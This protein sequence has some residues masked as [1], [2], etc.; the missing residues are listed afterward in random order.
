MDLWGVRITWTYSGAPGTGSTAAKRDAVRFLVKDTDEN[1]QLV[2]DEELSFAITS[3]GNLFRAAAL[4]CQELAAGNLG[5]KKVG[6]LEIEGAGRDY[7]SLA[8]EY[9]RRAS[10]QALP[11]VG[12]ISESAKDT[13]NQD[14]DRVKNAFT[15][16]LLS[17]VSLTGTTST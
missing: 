1:N 9:K 6:D 8:K 12:G 7:R 5:R 13:V 3:E 15:R 2:T 14:T 17:N 10:E 16:D 11:F 4:V